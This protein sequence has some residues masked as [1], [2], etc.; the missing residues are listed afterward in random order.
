MSVPVK[1]GGRELRNIPIPQNV[2]GWEN[3]SIGLTHLRFEMYYSFS[4]YPA[5]FALVPPIH[6]TAFI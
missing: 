2:G 3:D 1:V 4:F 6:V 5:R